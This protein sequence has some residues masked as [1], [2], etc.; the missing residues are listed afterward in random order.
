MVVQFSKILISVHSFTSEYPFIYSLAFVMVTVLMRC[1]DVNV[2][3]R[4]LLSDIRLM[5]NL[6]HKLTTVIVMR[7]TLLK[8][9]LIFTASIVWF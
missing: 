7:F 3:Q 2:G 6:H 5:E 4:N 1:G 9:F 8:D